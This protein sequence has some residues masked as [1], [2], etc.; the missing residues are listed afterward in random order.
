MLHSCER[1]DMKNNK[2]T[3]EKN[4][5]QNLVCYC[6]G[7]TA[8]DIKKDYDENGHSTIMNRILSEKKNGKCN[9]ETTNPKG[10]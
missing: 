7:Y 2:C 9:C 6:F 10:R 1:V 4:M 5:G 3:G 8:V